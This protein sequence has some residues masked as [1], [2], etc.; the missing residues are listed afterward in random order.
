VSPPLRIASRLVRRR[1]PRSFP[2]PW[3]LKQFAFRIGRTSRSK[4]VTCASL[5]CF[6][7]PDGRAGF[8][9]Q[10][11][12]GTSTARRAAAITDRTYRYFMATSRRAGLGERIH[13]TARRG[14]K[15]E[16]E[17]KEEKLDHCPCVNFLA[18]RGTFCRLFGCHPS[19]LIAILLALSRI[20]GEGR[21]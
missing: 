16:V 15:I 3:H 8:S 10:A 2:S 13:L 14:E 1:P 11:P 5:N 21:A 17:G 18:W 9:A 6:P 12:M 20:L 7:V 4:K 19:A